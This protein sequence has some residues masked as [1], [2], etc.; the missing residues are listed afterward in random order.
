VSS[1]DTETTH[2]R[3][4]L[5]PVGVL[6]ASDHRV[7]DGHQIFRC[8]PPPIQLKIMDEFEESRVSLSHARFPCSAQ[9]P[10]DGLA[11]SEDRGAKRGEAKTGSEDRGAKTGI[12]SVDF[13]AV[14]A[15][16]GSKLAGLTLDRTQPSP[17]SDD[18][19]IGPLLRNFG[20]KPQEHIISFCA[21]LD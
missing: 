3:A 21:A 15:R 6:A 13:I 20:I 19:E 4:S 18:L 12:A 1:K 10:A 5:S 7:E 2:F 16:F 8:E 11:G 17:T 14:A 9:V